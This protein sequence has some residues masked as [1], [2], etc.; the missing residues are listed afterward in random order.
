MTDGLLFAQLASNP[1]T[2]KQ[3]IELTGTPRCSCHS[4][5]RSPVRRKIFGS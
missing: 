4:Q 3:E 1:I 5:R 2:S